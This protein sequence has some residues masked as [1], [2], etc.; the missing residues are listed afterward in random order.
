VPKPAAVRAQPALKKRLVAEAD[1]AGRI[2]AREFAARLKPFFPEKS[3]H[4]AVACSGG[5]DSLSL[6]LLSADWAKSKGIRCTALIVDHGLRAESAAEARLTQRRLKARGIAAAILTWRGRKP[7]QGRQEAAREARYRLM[8]AWCARQGV[9]DLLLAHHQE[10]QAETFLLRAARGSGITG[11]GAMKPARMLSADLRLIRPLLDLPKARLRATLQALG[12]EWI[13]DPSNAD[14]AYARV[15]ARRMLAGM[16]PDAAGLIARSAA[17]AAEAAEAL[18]WAA[19]A[20]IE[21]RAAI[22]PAGGYWLDPGAFDALPDEIARR[23]LL[24]LLAQA[25]GQALPPRGEALEKLL[26]ALRAPD[27]RGATLARCA[28]IAL[29]AKILLCREARFL[30]PARK[31]KPGETLLWD[32]RFAIHAP[33]SAGFSVKALGATPWPA[34]AGMAI[35]AGLRPGLP[36]LCRG[37]RLVALPSLGLGAAPQGFRIAFSGPNRAVGA[38][39]SQA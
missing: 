22:D 3:A 37:A 34:W 14:P 21:A 36:A 15:R 27:F 10:D 7:S 12:Q 13:E 32:G 19:R 35:P 29:G 31:L 11:L 4:I 28:L 24:L 33:D 5:A 16:A 1:K 30:P 8:A 17:H 26:S 6:A 23:A 38:E 25:G 39:F 9:R 2:S 20:V 18:D